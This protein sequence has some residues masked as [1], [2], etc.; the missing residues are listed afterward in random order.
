MVCVVCGARSD[1]WDNSYKDTMGSPKYWKKI[2]RD[3][4]TPNVIAFCGPKCSLSW[5][6]SQLLTQ[7]PEQ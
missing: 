6:Q 4:K 7:K 2:N 3:P 5:E 1:T